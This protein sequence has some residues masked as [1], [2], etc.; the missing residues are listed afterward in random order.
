MIGGEFLADPGADVT[1]NVWQ[2]TTTSPGFAPTTTLADAWGRPLS[3]SAGG[4]ARS[5]WT[6]GDAGDP[7]GALSAT[8]AVVGTG[9]SAIEL[10]RTEYDYDADRRVSAISTV[11]AFGSPNE[12]VD[13]GLGYDEASRLTSIEGGPATATMAYDD[14]DNLVSVA[15]GGQPE[16]G[17]TYSARNLE[18]SYTPAGE[19]LGLTSTTTTWDA[20]ARPVTVT[21]GRAGSVTFGYDAVGRPATLT[22]D[23]GVYD[24]VVTTTYRQADGGVA[25]IGLLD[26]VDSDVK[27]AYPEPE[28]PFVEEQTLVDN[29]LAGTVALERDVDGRLMRRVVSVGAEAPVEL[30]ATYDD[31]PAATG[32]MSQF[33]PVVLH[34]QGPDG[35]GLLSALEVGATATE[36][37][38]DPTGALS[39][40]TTTTPLGTVADLTYMRDAAG[41]ITAITGTVEADTVDWT[42]GYDADGRLSQ[43]TQGA[44]PA[45]TNTYDA[46]GNRTERDVPGVATYAATY[47][48][49]DRLTEDS[50]REYEHNDAGQRTRM[51]ALTGAITDYGYDL[52][53][54][55]RHVALPDGGEIVYT[56]DGRGRRI[57][58]RVLDASDNVVSDTTWLYKDQLDPIAERDNLTGAVSVFVYASSRYSPDAMIRGGATYRFVTDHLG[59]VRLVLDAATGAAVQRIDYD[60][61]GNITLD[62]APEFQ[63]FGFAGGLHDRAT[64]FV[65][66]GARDYDP[67]T[68]RWTAKDPIRWGG[69]QGNLYEYVGSGPT[70]WTDP[71]GLIVFRCH[72]PERDRIF[73]KFEFLDHQYLHLS[74]SDE[75]FG[76]FPDPLERSSWGVVSEGDENFAD[77]NSRGRCID[78]GIK[79]KEEADLRRLA[80]EQANTSC[81]NASLRTTTCREYNLPSYVCSDWIDEMLGRFR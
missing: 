57:G 80:T 63:P 75:D 36:L 55:L 12:S 1:T 20:L 53:G 30:V 15:P 74:D 23:S 18:L 67:A 71:S 50:G 48:A 31:G 28:T 33:G 35:V 73:S 61:W 9:G 11:T 65:R 81:W 52:R 60:A 70:S 76:F 59:S 54:N 38:R 49:Q 51:T 21:F 14:N 41:R 47:D 32:L 6:Y 37:T 29:L 19:E 68:G 17:T 44:A 69:G 56:V 72:R 26:G 40:A 79:D 39:R 46:N 77:D 8:G 27:L 78:T 10:S 24:E 7:P 5:W 43:E 34:R 13:V 16:H 45:I 25:M 42:Y 64:G 3:A 2:T 22:E 58:R 4:L 62:T 66:F